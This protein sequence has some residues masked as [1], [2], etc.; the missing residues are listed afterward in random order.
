[1]YTEGDESTVTHNQ[2]V[3]KVDDL[4]LLCNNKIEE[5]ID[6]H[7]VSWILPHT[8]TDP[9]RVNKSNIKYP[10][11]VLEENGILYLL[12]GAHRLTKMV[13]KNLNNVQVFILTNE[14]VK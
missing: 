12:D 7:L 6:I 5:S 2:H 11:I 1:M 13:N 4:I 3:F 9:V 10:L 8:S 14:D